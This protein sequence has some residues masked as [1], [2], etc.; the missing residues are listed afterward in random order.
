MEFIG[1]TIKEKRKSLKI[2]QNELGDKVGS[3][4]ISIGHLESGKNVGTNLL[5]KVC[6]ELNLE[7]SVKEKEV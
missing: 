5:K 2:T 1:K 7:L 6:N 4:Y 3:C